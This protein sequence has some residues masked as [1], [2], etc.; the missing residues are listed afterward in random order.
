MKRKYI[1]E[2]CFE[3]FDIKDVFWCMAKNKTHQYILCKK[4]I[5]IIKPKEYKPVK[6]KKKKQK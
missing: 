5:E 3:E 1:C 6:Q 2:E 4:C